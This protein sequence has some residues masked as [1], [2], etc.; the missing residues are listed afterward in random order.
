MAGPRIAGAFFMLSGR[1]RNLAHH[2][3]MKMHY[4]G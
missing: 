3:E 2:V 4:V 1:K